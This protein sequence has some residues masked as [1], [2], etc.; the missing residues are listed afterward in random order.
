MANHLV[1]VAREVGAYPPHWR[2]TFEP[3]PMEDWADLHVYD[4][5][6]WVTPEGPSEAPERNK[7]AAPSLSVTLAD[8]A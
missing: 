8:S 7:D 4:G 5:G 2:G 1:R 3:V 6:R